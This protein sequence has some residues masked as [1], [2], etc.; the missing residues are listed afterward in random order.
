[1][2]CQRCFPQ[3]IRK[4]LSPGK[5]TTQLNTAEISFPLC[6]RENLV[7]R[8]GKERQNGFLFAADFFK[9]QFAWT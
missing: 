4:N 7:I 3:S 9:P 1:M 2:V 8:S 5:E 6:C